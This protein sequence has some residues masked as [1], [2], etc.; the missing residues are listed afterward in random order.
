MVVATTLQ[1]LEDHGVDGS[2]TPT[3]TLETRTAPRSTVVEPKA[4]RRVGTPAR[5][6]SPTARVEP[7]QVRLG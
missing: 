4:H 7:G 6:G 3:A 5:S 2:H 1:R